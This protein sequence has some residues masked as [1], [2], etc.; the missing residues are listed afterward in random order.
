[1]MEEHLRKLLQNQHTDQMETV[2]AAVNTGTDVPKIHLLIV[3]VL[4]KLY[5]E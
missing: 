2:G 3:S 5:W 4:P 1:M